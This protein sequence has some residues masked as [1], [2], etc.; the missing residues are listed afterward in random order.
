MGWENDNRFERKE[1]SR[2]T[3]ISVRRV[4]VAVIC[5]FLLS[6]FMK[7]KEAFCCHYLIIIVAAIYF[8]ENSFPVLVSF[9]LL[10]SLSSLLRRMFFNV[11]RCL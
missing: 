1:K 3:V 7:E 11:S 9:V 8:H 6:G 10:P 4:A 2:E 5:L